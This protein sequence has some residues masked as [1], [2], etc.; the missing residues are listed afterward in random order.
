MAVPL[1]AVGEEVSLSITMNGGAAGTI[2]V[3]GA[4]WTSAGIPFYN[5]EA[6][7]YTIVIEAC[8]SSGACVTVEK[9]VPN[10][11]WAEETGPTVDPT[12]L[13][14]PAI[15]E[16]MPAPGIGITL[17]GIAIALFA[18]RKKQD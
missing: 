3:N 4:E 7:D 16:S 10:L 6:G 13:P 15:D 11:Y 12:V 2:E 18:S 8:D 17:A 9:L 5:Y 14:E 1:E